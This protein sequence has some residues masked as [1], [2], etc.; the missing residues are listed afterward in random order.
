[1]TE[2]KTGVCDCSQDCAWCLAA[3]CAPCVVAGI[4]ADN[5]GKNPFIWG[6]GYLV[7]APVFGG[8]LRGELRS[9]NSIEVISIL[10]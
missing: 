8:I 3:C 7:C 5:M 9:N 6:I 2:W 10:S 1:M 4:N